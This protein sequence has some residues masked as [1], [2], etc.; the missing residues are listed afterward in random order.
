[1][2]RYDAVRESRYDQRD[3]ES[4]SLILPDAA[5]IPD[6]ENADRQYTWIHVVARIV[7]LPTERDKGKI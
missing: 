7:L 3:L 6:C 2:A 1:V 4:A 5:S